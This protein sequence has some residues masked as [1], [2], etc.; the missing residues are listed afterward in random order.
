MPNRIIKES[1]CVSESISEL[2]W[3]EE[4]LF[5]RLIVSCDDYG[6]FDGRIQVIKNRLFPLKDSLTAK[7]VG[8][9]IN[10]LV[11]VGLVSLYEYDGKPFLYLPSW[12]DHQN[13]RAHKS[14]YPAPSENANA[15]AS[16]CMQMISDECKC[17]RNPIQSNPIQSESEYE[18]ESYSYSYT[19]PGTKSGNNHTQRFSPPSVEDVRKYCIDRGNSVDAEKFVD[20]Y[21]SNGWMVGKNRMKDWKAAVRTWEKNSGVNDGKN[22]KFRE[23]SSNPFLDLLEDGDYE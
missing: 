8:E 12:N 19:V 23:K 22:Q 21:T 4:V 15:S 11:R 5:Y 1:I 6:R 7:N 14:K 16:K 18:S 2:S 17:S 13:I 20:Y 10:K 9:A 3:F